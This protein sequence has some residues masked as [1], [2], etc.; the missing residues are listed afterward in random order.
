MTVDATRKYV[1]LFGSRSE[2]ERLCPVSNCVKSPTARLNLLFILATTMHFS[3]SNN[4]AFRVPAFRVRSSIVLIIKVPQLSSSWITTTQKTC[5]QKI[6]SAN[7]LVSM[8]R[9]CEF[10]LSY[11]TSYL[12]TFSSKKKLRKLQEASG[13]NSSS[14]SCRR[15]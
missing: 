5:S 13:L 7:V 1:V 9:I 11:T 12:T 4:S 2:T 10:C 15:G 6:N 14:Y 3:A 8:L